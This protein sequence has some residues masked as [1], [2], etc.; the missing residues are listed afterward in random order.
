M[1]RGVD[2][3]DIIESLQDLLDEAMEYGRKFFDME[4][5]AQRKAMKRPSGATYRGQSMRVA[6]LPAGVEARPHC[7]WR[8][9]MVKERH[10][11]TNRQ[12]RTRGACSLRLF[13]RRRRG[14]MLRWRR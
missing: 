4:P 14:S 5:K 7:R 8:S 11:T 6:K 9:A 1:C 10:K 3:N 12:K 13:R 2:I